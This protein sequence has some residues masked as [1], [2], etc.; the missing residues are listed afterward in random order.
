MNPS[1][2]Q[3]PAWV[4]ALMVRRIPLSANTILEPTPGEGNLVKAIKVEFPN[5][6]VYEG[7]PFHCVDCIV[8]NPP[9]TPMKLGYEMLETF[10]KL[11]SNIVII[12]PW[13][14]LINSQKRTKDYIE[15][16]L[17][18]IIHLPRS[19]FAGSRVQTCILIFEKG[20]QGQVTFQ[21]AEEL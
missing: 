10:F 8:A 3:T 19:V 13:L 7:L 14:A 11:S 9:F 4:C 6:T 2:F 5:A 16:G 18:Q 15:R 20:Y 12:M 21:V 17:K 1:D